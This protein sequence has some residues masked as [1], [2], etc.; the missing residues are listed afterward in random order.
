MA[1]GAQAGSESPRLVVAAPPLRFLA[2]LTRLGLP[3]L[4]QRQLESFTKAPAI[5]TVLPCRIISWIG[6]ESKVEHG[7]FDYCLAL[8]PP[9]RVRVRH[10]LLQEHEYSPIDACPTLNLQVVALDES[11]LQ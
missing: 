10:I 9:A 4:I 6:R 5:T 1:A 8:L 2:L 11:P 7:H 3:T